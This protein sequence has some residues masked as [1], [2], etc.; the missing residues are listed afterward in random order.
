[1][2]RRPTRLLLTVALAGSLA[3]CGGG[4]PAASDGPVATGIQPG[5]TLIGTIGTPEDPDEYVIGLTDASGATVETLPAGDY[6][7][8]VDDQSRIHNWVLSGDGVD[9]VATEVSGTGEQSFAVTLKAGEYGY[10]C[11]PHPSMSG[12]VKVT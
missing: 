6:T 5:A 12:T 10:V 4:G 7:I 3:A 1:M 9:G 11:D 2:L 8:T